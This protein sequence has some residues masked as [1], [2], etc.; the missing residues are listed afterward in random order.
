MQVLQGGS[1][2]EQTPSLGRYPVLQ[3]ETQV[4]VWR[5]KGIDVLHELQ[6]K[7]KFMQVRQL[8]LQGSQTLV[9]MFSIERPVGHEGRH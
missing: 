5:Y 6:E 1:Q 4:L 2:G 3:V 7:T 8:V 9:V